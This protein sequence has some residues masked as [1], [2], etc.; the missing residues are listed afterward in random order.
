MQ[1]FLIYSSRAAFIIHPFV[2]SKKE[3]GSGVYWAGSAQYTPQPALWLI[4]NG[5]PFSA[6][7]QE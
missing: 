5:R 2:S 4:I 6:D 7:E 3:G 1:A